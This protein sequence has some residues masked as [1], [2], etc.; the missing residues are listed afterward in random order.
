MSY[1]E[2][3]C[4][5]S[6]KTWSANCRPLLAMPSH[7]PPINHDCPQ[8][9]PCLLLYELYQAI[10]TGN[11]ASNGQRPTSYYFYKLYYINNNNIPRKFKMEEHLESYPQE[12]ALLQQ[13]I[14][15]KASSQYTRPQIGYSMPEAGRNR[16]ECCCWRFLWS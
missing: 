8:R 14:E 7:T 10:S 13:F 5:S 6:S 2:V 15:L 4:V 11:T 16:L 3:S 1:H 12:T 9:L